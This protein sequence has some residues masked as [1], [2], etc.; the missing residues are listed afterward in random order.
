MKLCPLP[1]T[2]LLSY[3]KFHYKLC[4]VDGQLLSEFQLLRCFR[5]SLSQ[6][7]RT[8]IIKIDIQYIFLQTG[9]VSPCLS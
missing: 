1:Q 8:C 2:V 9:I 4:N 6:E 3:W 7:K 5:F